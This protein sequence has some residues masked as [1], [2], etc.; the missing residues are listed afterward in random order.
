MKNSNY[1]FI[2]KNIKCFKNGAVNVL[3]TDLKKIGFQEKPTQL[4]AGPAE[5][6]QQVIAWLSMHEFWIG[7]LSSLVANQIEKVLLIFYSWYKNQKISKDKTRP[8]VSI[9]VHSRV[10]KLKTKYLTFYVDQ[11]NSKPEIIK[12]LKN[13]D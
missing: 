4:G 2:N 1:Y 10:N 7:V 12:Q 5:I 13:K 11:V 8:V 3:A 9:F 6:P